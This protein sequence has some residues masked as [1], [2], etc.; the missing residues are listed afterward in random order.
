M[1]S[2]PSSSSPTAF[3]STQ[4]GWNASAGSKRRRGSA[5]SND[6]GTPRAAP[7]PTPSLAL[8][9]KW[10]VGHSIDCV[11]ENPAQPGRL[12]YN[13]EVRKL[14]D[15][16][17][18]QPWGPECQARLGNSGDDAFRD[19]APNTPCTR[20][21][22]SYCKYGA[23]YRK[24]TTF[25]T[26]LSELRLRQQCSSSC[27]CP[28]LRR[29]DKHPELVQ[30][31]TASKKNSIP[32]T[33][34]HEV[35]ATFLEKQRAEGRKVFM[36]VDVFSGWGSVADAC[37]EHQLRAAG[38]LRADERF[39]V[40]TNDIVATRPGVWVDTDLDMSRLDVAT[41]VRF[42][43]VRHADALY[44][45]GVEKVHEPS[46]SL[47]SELAAMGVGVLLHCSVPCTTYSVAAGNAHRNKGD[48]APVSDLAK[49]HDALTAR[50]VASLVEVCSL[51]Q[52]GAGPP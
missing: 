7:R 26:S 48:I 10:R 51:R 52:P 19:R 6:D 2:L 27:P 15:P 28:A 36:L 1:S 4:D 30:G 13:E 23:A 46:A 33:L 38:V 34:V 21:T 17:P 5:A 42:A 37:S 39:F 11:I 14:Y 45:L 49:A 31:C 25:L 47:A 44:K 12:W 43:C 18:N 32:Q 41:L 3:H 24:N 35:V 8:A 50:T 22:T 9:P 29:G 40:H 20:V 16:T